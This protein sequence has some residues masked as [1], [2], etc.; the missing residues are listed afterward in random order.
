MSKV[1]TLFWILALLAVFADSAG[2]ITPK[3]PVTLDGCY[4]I[5][6]KEELYGFAEIVNGSENVAPKQ[7][8]CARIGKSI[9]VN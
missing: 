9:F 3:T 2:T 1:R 7:T 5:T 4:F 6:S 8:A